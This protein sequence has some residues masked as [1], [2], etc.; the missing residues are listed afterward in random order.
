MRKAYRK[1]S[2]VGRIRFDKAGQEERVKKQVAA[3]GVLRFCSF[4]KRYNMLS[5]NTCCFSQGVIKLILKRYISKD[6]DWR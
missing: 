4:I 5:K 6:H 1:L 2:A 3:G